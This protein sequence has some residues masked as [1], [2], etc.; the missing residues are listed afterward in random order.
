MASATNTNE[1][2]SIATPAGAVGDDC[3]WVSGWDAETGGNFLF[4]KSISTNP[5]PL[6]LGDRYRLQ[7]GTLTLVYNPSV[8]ETDDMAERAIRGKIANGMWIQYHTANPGS[9]GSSN[10]ISELGRTNIAQ[11]AFTVAQ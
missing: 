6:A 3:T 5:A 4:R 1:V 11:S 8:D 2:L 9:S 10:A 7:A